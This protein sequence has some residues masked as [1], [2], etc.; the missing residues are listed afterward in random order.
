MVSE[1][2]FFITLSLIPYMARDTITRIFYSFDDSKT[3][4]IVAICS[5][6][7]KILMNAIFVKIYGIGGIMLSTTLVTIFNATLLSILILRKKVSLDYK[8]FISPLIKMTFAT[9]LTAG[10]CVG[11]NYFYM[12]IIPDV[13]WLSTFIKLGILFIAGGISYF[14]FALLF[15]ISVARL[16][17]ERILAKIRR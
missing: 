13:T 15:K 1:A 9:L 3:P 17:V 12:N 8:G 14:L 16:V 10:I 4:F 11:I 2:L 6:A 5:V 7:I